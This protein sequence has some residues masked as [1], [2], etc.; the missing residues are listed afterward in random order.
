[1]QT[2][3]CN[4]FALKKVSK[5]LERPSVL[6]AEAFHKLLLHVRQPYRNMVLIADC[7][8][9]RAS[10]IVGLQWRDLDFQKA[11]LLVQRGVVHGRVDDVKTEYS[12][13]VPIAPVLVKEFDRVS[14]SLLP[15]GGGLAVRK[16]C[17]S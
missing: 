1:L 17:D 10:E 8:G 3:Q 15:D 7:L 14:V 9:L 6:T 12:G 13:H 11:T 16:P 5:R 4:W 2:T